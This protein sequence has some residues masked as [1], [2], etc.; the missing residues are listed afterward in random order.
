[1]RGR[2]FLTWGVLY[3]KRK[4]LNHSSSG[5]TIISNVSG[6]SVLDFPF[7]GKNVE[8]DLLPC[9]QKKKLCGVLWGGRRYM[10]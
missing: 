6:F 7:S 4:F 3:G 10:S 2:L 5:F 1:M 8:S 9:S